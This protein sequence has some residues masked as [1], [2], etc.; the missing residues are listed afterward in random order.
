MRAFQIFLMLML[1]LKISEHP[2]LLEESGYKVQPDTLV[3][4]ERTVQ[5]EKLEKVVP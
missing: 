1:M 3:R 2:E 4:L 5:Q